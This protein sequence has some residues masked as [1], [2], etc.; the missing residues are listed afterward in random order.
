MSHAWADGDEA[1]LP[2]H[3]RRDYL[4][5][6]NTTRTTKHRHRKTLTPA[7]PCVV[8]FKSEVDCGW[9]PD[10]KILVIG[11]NRI[12][13]ASHAKALKARWH[14]IQ[15]INASGLT[16]PGGVPFHSDDFVL[17]DV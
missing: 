17:V 14:T 3:R 6:G 2:R 8:K 1:E 11:G 13:F 16:Q 9:N 15:N 10:K 7:K 12:I 4:K 5:A